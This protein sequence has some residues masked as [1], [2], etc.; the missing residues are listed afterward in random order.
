MTQPSNMND[1]V[2][3]WEENLESWNVQTFENEN[4]AFQGNWIM[5][6]CYLN[7]SGI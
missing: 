2:K 1:I 5:K 6:F 3:A 7:F 4:E